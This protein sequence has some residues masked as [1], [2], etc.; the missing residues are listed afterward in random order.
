M[1]PKTTVC[2]PAGTVPGGLMSGQGARPHAAAADC[3]DVKEP[4][5]CAAA[6][7]VSMAATVIHGYATLLVCCNI[8]L[9]SGA[10]TAHSNAH[11]C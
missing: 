2:R 7:T 8:P 5:F 6:I 10:A 4:M 11:C 1:L 9:L 3:D